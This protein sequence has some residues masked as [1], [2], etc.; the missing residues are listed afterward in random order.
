MQMDCLPADVLSE[1]FQYIPYDTLIR[2]MSVCTLWWHTIDSIVNKSSTELT[3]YID[4]DGYISLTVGNKQNAT[5]SSRFMREPRNVSVVKQIY[6]ILNQ[7]KRVIVDGTFPRY[8]A[9]DY[10]VPSYMTVVIRE[11][12]VEFGW[13][14]GLV[15][16]RK[17]IYELL[18][19]F[20][21]ILAKLRPKN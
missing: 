8:I 7:R 9:Y 20:T 13:A 3:T 19:L 1:I 11:N 15:V 14:L 4:G 6:D 5:F 10:R 2:C 12:C 18:R 16:P 17:N 21:F